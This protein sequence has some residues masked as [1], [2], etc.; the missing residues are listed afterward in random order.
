[1]APV[2]S[3]TLPQLLPAGG[4]PVVKARRPVPVQQL[5]LG[6]VLVVVTE[7]LVVVSPMLEVVV[8][9]VDVEVVATVSV[10]LVLMVEV[11]VVT[12]FAGH[13]QSS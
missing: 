5:Q 12:A 6:M 7:V 3:T 2:S 4:R 8:S 10:V 1:L 13:V 9:L 11:V